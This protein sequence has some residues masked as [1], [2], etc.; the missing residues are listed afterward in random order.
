[1]P[2]L[3]S[4]LMGLNHRLGGIS[5]RTHFRSLLSDLGIGTAQIGLTVTFLAYQA[6][7]MSD[8]I[9][10]TL[11]RLFIT[12]RNL[13]QWVTAAQ[14]KRGMDLK[15]AG[16]Y[17]RM[18]GGIAAIFAA[19]LC[20]W[21]GQLWYGRPAWG[22]ASAFMVLW[23]AAPAMARWISLPPQRE[24][25]ESVSELDG[26]ALRLI[27][28]RTW[29]FFERL[30]TAEDRWL[31]PDNFQVDP[32][33][34]LAHRTSPTN[35]GLC[36]LSTVAA[37]DFGWLGLS[38][39]VERLDNTLSTMGQLELYRG[40]FYNWYNT[41]DLTPLEPRYVSS[42]D[43][44][45]L[46]G[47]LLALANACRE[48]PAEPLGAVSFFEGANDSL[49]LLRR[50][51]TGMTDT[52]RTQTVTRKQF[53]RAVDEL[54]GL[55]GSPPRDAIT[56]S[57]RL[58]ALR[59][60]AYTLAD[61]AHTLAHERGIAPD[62]ELQV[63]A[64]AI[65][66][67]VKS[68]FRD[69][70]IL[71]PWIRLESEQITSV[72]SRIPEGAPEWFAIEPFFRE[73]PSLADSRD[74]FESALRE[75]GALRAKAA[76]E[77]APDQNLLARIDT[78]SYAIQ[79]SAADA[80]GV[81]RR[82]TTLTETAETIFKAMDFGFLFDDSRK[83]FYIGYRVPDS[84]PDPTC[85]D[86]LA[87]EARLTSFVAIAK[88]DVPSSHWFRLARA[89]TPIG[90][91]SALVSWSG[92]MFEYL[93][94]DLVMRSPA[95][96][97]LRQ[98]YEQVVLRQ[99]EYGGQ[100][101]VPWGISESA[102]NARDLNFTYQYSSFGVPGLGLRRGLSDDLVIAP[103]ATALAAMIRPAA[104]VKNFMRLE[105]DGGSGNYGFYDALDYTPERI[106][107]HARVAPVLTYM[108]H[109]QGM[110]IIAL[111]NV[112][113][114][115]VMQTR[116]H[117]EPIIQA[118]E[119]LLQERTPRDVL[120]TRP[121]EEEVSA[122]QVREMVPPVLRR[123]NTPHDVLPRTHLLA[124]GSYSVMF[125][126][127]G[128]GYSR[129]RD[130]A[131]TRWRED[132]TRDCWG[133]YFYM[134]DQQS[135]RIWSAGYQ[136]TCMEPDTYEVAF[137]EDRA[138][139]A[140]RDGAIT[141]KLE[142]IV[143]SEDD[144]EV[145]RISLINKGARGR[146]IQVTSFAEICLA[147]Q[148]ADAAHP[149]FSNLFVQ[150][151]FAAEMAAIL[152]T[153]RKQSDKETTIW[154]AQVLVVEGE[155]LGDLQYETDRGRFIGRGRDSRNPV[156]VNDG[157]PLSNTTG[158]VLDPMMG[159]RRTVRIAPGATA[160]LIFST[161]VAADREQVLELADKYRNART[162]ERTLALA[163][164]QAQIQLHHLGISLDEALLFQRLANAVLYPDPTIRSTPVMSEG[165]LDRTALW[166]QGISGDL[167]VVLARIDEPDDIEII[168][169]LLRAHEYW[170]MKQL[171]A[172]LVILNERPASYA[173]DL[174]GS[175]DA[176]VRGSQLRLAPDNSSVRGNIF[177]LRADLIS[178]PTR[179]ALQ[180]I[181]RVV[182]LSRRGTLSEQIL[183]SPRVETPAPRSSG[184][185]KSAA[186]QSVDL[187]AH[188][189]EHFNGLG[190]FTE[191]GREYVTVLTEGMRT[192][193]PWVNVI[194]NPS[195]GFLASESGSGFTW[196]LNSHENQLTPWSND[197]VTDAAGEAFYIRDES[198]GEVWTPTA[199]PIRHEALTYV[200]SHG[201]GYSR[202]QHGS[203]G[204]VAD[205][206]Q[207][208]P[209]GDPVKISRLIL[210]NVSGRARR[211]SV[212]TY[213][214]LVLGSSR[215]VL[216]PYVITEIDSAS[217]ALLAR[218]KWAGD[219]GGRIVFADMAGKQTSWT[220][221]RKE[222][223]GR[224]GSPANPAALQPDARLSGKVGS[225]LDACAAL[226]TAIDLRAGASVEIVFF[227]GEAA[228]VGKA[229]DLLARY[230][231]A[232]L[233]RLFAEVTTGWKE[234][235]GAVQV[236]TPDASMNILL[237]H[238]LLYQTLACRV[239][240][241]TGFYQA[242]GA[243]GFRDQLQDVMA[244][245]VAQPR[246]AR[247]HLLRAAG[248]QF[249]EGDVQHWWHP[250]S[251]RGVRTRISDDFLWLPF[252]VVHYIETTGDR[253]VL[254]EIVPFLEGDAIAAGQDESYFLPR[255]S[256]TSGTLFEHCARALDRGLAVGA[257]DLPLMGTG[258]WNDGMN[259]VGV[260]GHGESV[261]LGWFLHSVLWEGAK[262]ADD[263][264]ES[265]RAETWRIH[266][267]ALTA[268]LEKAG[269]DGEW[270]RRAYYDDGS[271]LG[272]SE[273][274]ECRIDS[275]AQSWGVISGGAERVRASR[276]MASVDQQLIRRP[277]GLVLL[278]TPPFDR[279]TENP[280]YIKGYPPGIRENGG[281][282]THA[283]VWTMLG[284]AALGDGD[285]A[286][287]LFEMLNPINRANSR[288]NVQR[289]K[290]EP[291]AVAGD[292]SSEPPH[293]GRGGWT[294]YTGSAGWLY[295]G[296]LEWILGF[297]LRGKTLSIDPCIPARWRG[298]S[299]T[300]RYHSAV[301]EIK[302][303][304][305]QGV[306]RGV[307]RSEVDGVATA[308]PGTIPLDA[309][310]GIHAVRIVLGETLRSISK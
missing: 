139:I 65:L 146:D 216:S 186:L 220:G 221:D 171:S 236:Q 93:M 278:F 175:L 34:V 166:S 304:N 116:F 158:F 299:I 112:V 149:A 23:A 251:G 72:A 195:F 19:A 246:I 211:L 285:K 302:V 130:I 198:T 85:Y 154:V 51:M 310:R 273:N 4:F 183:R 234:T 248:R 28:R 94:P 271:P 161:I 66:G 141:T 176:L 189:L 191:R 150:T 238:W 180:S 91:G 253:A 107:E 84:T 25:E 174:Q 2:P 260:G 247:E 87:S 231:A 303:E 288:V 196:S 53:V 138:E 205:L 188:A 204:I 249:L 306:C 145:R 223:L 75:L 308:Q 229:R 9:L 255:E 219:F 266:V 30:V 151:E 20:L 197:P 190:G 165:L 230:R 16:V 35:M 290:T 6:W 77:D 83:L 31:P 157:R 69:A 135:G 225:D 215:N 64:D 56:W 261:W 159:L 284:F 123:L 256:S 118:S 101:G 213:A 44:G 226:R 36:L 90:R 243:Y 17:R 265:K 163:W 7:L 11:G 245:C 272:S 296:G 208:V 147:P 270:Y 164:T 228:D 160:R 110:T 252:A 113:N 309:A 262:I 70:E 80:A 68:H 125:T 27:S 287:E 217:K 124:N 283:A 58:G 59:A 143:S 301:Y 182:L 79:N 21:Y 98:T 203:H 307:T 201:L 111:D 233:S 244:L 277:E 115:G 153:R 140:R 103:Y 232:D 274:Q 89:L 88:G 41:Q 60:Q 172:D 49:E 126:A 33:P 187:P 81:L 42:V 104:A 286:A 168:R 100:R 210:R 127:A 92:S 136:P 26:N 237:N 117:A 96:S 61:I 133:M 86:L 178:A 39:T 155:T 22:C 280:G 108:A 170:R 3:L 222:F 293:K 45:N 291:Y 239:W 179:A 46:A 177:L 185:Q 50:S 82:C 15:L 279:T 218:S 192:P 47:H 292:V 114:D 162:F 224:N 268:A 67:C 119:L 37:H 137:S 167:P 254:E 78:L 132:V 212:T 122:A 38:E 142:V 129:W 235:L 241:R 289:Y 55:L 295:R 184:T 74:R 305:P 97:L 173:Q 29:R 300:F 202:F 200:A 131:V 48:M 40:H 1:V 258:D 13:L 18:A 207:F 298:Y 144:V 102:Y 5:K 194:A 259:R 276:A 242:S 193:Q 76:G 214:E 263:R 71:L 240:A 128:S 106:P 121:G 156:C 63:W 95:G 267:K 57:L 73:M 43:S 99:M 294:W 52:A 297:R 134:R 120:V 281:Q 169:Q 264:G 257:H 250:P 109:H 269:W 12:H 206:L 24:G 152:A 209:P 227:L 148:A 282:Y 10:R 54:A 62:S 275:I 8:A 14:S 181:A 199:L 105:D 32:K